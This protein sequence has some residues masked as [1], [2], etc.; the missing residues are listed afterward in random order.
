M[1]VAYESSVLE[2]SQIRARQR[3]R[4]KLPGIAKPQRRKEGMLFTESIDEGRKSAPNPT[5]CGW[6]PANDKDTWR[7]DILRRAEKSECEKF[8]PQ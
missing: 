7:E 8:M 3:V 1:L 6:K 4:F 5:V 2:K